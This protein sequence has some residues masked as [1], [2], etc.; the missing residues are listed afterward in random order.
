MFGYV[1]SVAWTPATSGSNPSETYAAA[2]NSF[3]YTQ[4]GT[5]TTIA[6]NNVRPA[7]RIVSTLRQYQAN[8]TGG[9]TGGWRALI[10]TYKGAP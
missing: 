1:Q 4:V 9:G 2:P 8:G 10:A 6:G 5:L 7:Y 3:P